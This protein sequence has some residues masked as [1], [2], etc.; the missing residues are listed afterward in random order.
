MSMERSPTAEHQ[1]LKEDAARTKNWK[2]WGPYLSERQWATVR[3]D[4]ALGGLSI[5]ETA[6]LLQAI[7]GVIAVTNL[8][9]AALLARPDSGRPIAMLP[10]VVPTKP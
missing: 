1:R 7:I 10:R 3:E 5:T 6:E 2:R 9:L 8:I 4:A